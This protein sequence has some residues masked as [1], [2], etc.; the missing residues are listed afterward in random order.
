MVL[1]AERHAPVIGGDKPAIGDGDPMGVTQQL[2]EHGPR[3]AGVITCS[4][5]D[6]GEPHGPAPPTPP[7][8]RVRTRR[9][10]RLTRFAGH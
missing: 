6:R 1:P 5:R 10:G 3:S 4:N 9:F 2:G 7:W 8:I